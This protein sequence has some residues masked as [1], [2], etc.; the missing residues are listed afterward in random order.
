MWEEED[1]DLPLSG[2]VNAE[3]KADGDCPG[4]KTLICFICFRKGAIAARSVNQNYLQPYQCNGS[5]LE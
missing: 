3:E 5:S 2:M 4:R 1:Q